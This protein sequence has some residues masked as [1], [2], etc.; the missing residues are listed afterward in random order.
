MLA[1]THAGPEYLKQAVLKKGT[2][3]W[4]WVTSAGNHSLTDNHP[5]TWAA[6]FYCKQSCKMNMSLV[7][8]ESMRAEQ[9]EHFWRDWADLIGVP[10][11]CRF[12]QI[13]PECHMASSWQI[14]PE[15]NLSDQRMIS[16]SNSNSLNGVK[17]LDWVSCI[18]S[19]RWTSWWI[20]PTILAPWKPQIWQFNRVF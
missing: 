16:S 2:L 20:S 18:P 10:S 6:F 12:G 7:T 5:Y 3:K 11:G 17:H 1:P 19:C 15:S 8:M 4:R 13:W 9:G 14:W